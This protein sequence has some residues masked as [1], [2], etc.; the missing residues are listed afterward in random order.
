MGLPEDTDYSK[1]TPSVLHYMDAYGMAPAID[2]D[3]KKLA[4]D[5]ITKT[6]SYYAYGRIGIIIVIPDQKRVVYV[7]NG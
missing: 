3:I 1:Q 4:D 6:G 2:S 5:A 7:F